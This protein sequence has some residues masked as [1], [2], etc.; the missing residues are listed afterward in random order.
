MKTRAT[1]SLTK[2]PKSNRLRLRLMDWIRRIGLITPSESPQSLDIIDHIVST[3]TLVDC[4]ENAADEAELKCLLK[5]AHQT[6][7]QLQVIAK[8]IA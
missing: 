5:N 6:A 1:K 8:T 7:L 3:G 4:A 2:M